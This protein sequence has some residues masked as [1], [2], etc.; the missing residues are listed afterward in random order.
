M[1]EFTET[2]KAIA[3]SLQAYYNELEQR[4]RE[5]EKENTILRKE[6]NEKLKYKEYIK[7]IEEQMDRLPSVKDKTK[8]VELIRRYVDWTYCLLGKLEEIS[9]EEGV[10]KTNNFGY[11]EIILLV[12]SILYHYYTDGIELLTNCSIEGK[13]SDIRYMDFIIRKVLV[14]TADIRELD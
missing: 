6:A 8:K 5:L 3:D 1:K 4:I 12:R 9:I 14:P 11:T 7:S 10:P 2:K 13:K